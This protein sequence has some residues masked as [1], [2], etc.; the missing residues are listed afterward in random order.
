VAGGV[1]TQPDRVSC[2][3]HR[4]GPG[5]WGSVVLAT[6]RPAQRNDAGDGGHEGHR[7]NAESNRSL[8]DWLIA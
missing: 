3:S 8:P 2:A 1:S 4:V 7:G 5:R 6:V